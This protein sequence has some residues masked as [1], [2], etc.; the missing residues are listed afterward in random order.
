M[1][2]QWADQA[3][4]DG[5]RRLRHLRQQ[6]ASAMAGIMAT[7]SIY[8]VIVSCTACDRIPDDGRLRQLPVEHDNGLGMV[9]DERGPS[10]VEAR[11]TRGN[12][13]SIRS[14]DTETGDVWTIQLS[15]FIDSTTG[16]LRTLSVSLV[17]P[18]KVGPTIPFFQ[19]P[20][21]RVYA[22]VVSASASEKKGFGPGGV[23]VTPL[24]TW[25]HVIGEADLIVTRE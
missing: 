18:A 5:V 12:W 11:V 22:T 21:S 13:V 4:L 25:G 10:K 15:P 16:V 2:Q 23:W 19:S 8:A 6:L 17:H 7:G 20:R 1:E 14:V 24:G 3:V 9:V